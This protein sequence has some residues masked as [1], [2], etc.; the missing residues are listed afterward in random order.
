M[1]LHTRSLLVAASRFAASPRSYARWLDSPNEGTHEL[2]IH[3]C[4]NR[5][6]VDAFRRKKL[7]C[8]FCVVDSCGLDVNLLETCCG[9]FAAIFLISERS[10]KAAARLQHTK[11][12]SQYT[13]LVRRQVDYAIRDNHIDRV[14]RQRDM[15]DLAL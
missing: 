8:I 10:R 4:C 5:V 13:I 9:E 7:T 15:L 14:V 3:V 2:A 11:G 6:H 12:F 1:S